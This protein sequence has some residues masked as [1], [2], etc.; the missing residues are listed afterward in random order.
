M[1]PS[2]DMLV[3]ALAL[4]VAM[5]LYIVGFRDLLVAQL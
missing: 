2:R 5:A 1:L 4:G 3:V